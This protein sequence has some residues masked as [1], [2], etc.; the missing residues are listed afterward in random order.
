MVN[1]IAKISKSQS[2]F[3]FGARGT[4]KSTLLKSISFL[5]NA[6]VVDLLKPALEERY[7]IDPEF[8]R[9][10]CLSLNAGDWVIIDE[11][12][13]VPK[14]LN[15]V[16]SIIEELKINFALTGSSSRKLKRGSANML[17]GRAVT[18]SLFPFTAAELSIDFNLNDILT[19][20]SL[21]SI[22]HLTK[23][24]D[25][26]R[27]L[28]GYVFN[29]LKE[30][31]VAEQLVRNLDP[32]RLFLPIAAQMECQIINY[33]NIAKDS[34]VEHKTIQNYFQILVDTNIGFFLDSY[35][36]SVRKVQKQ[37]PK[38][39]FFDGGVKRALERKI[40]LKLE[41]STTDYGNAFEAWFIN[42]CYRMNSYLE[43][44]LKFS[45]LRTKDDV[46]IDLIV[47]KPDG[48]TLLVEIKSSDKIDKRHVK[49]LNH[50]KKD[51]AGAEFICASRVKTIQIIEDVKVM[52]YELA[53]KKII[54]R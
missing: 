12:Q 40:T 35:N 2:F 52:P 34:G 18:Y 27:Y 21:P 26:A 9:Q 28:R 16:H 30:E 45:Y 5:K 17:G 11:V 54:E 7:S 13:K 39:Y 8:L 44:D 33:S 37:A 41:P 43:L 19:W 49:N 51:F 15:I 48:Q 47:E 20:G 31:V 25:K 22:F 36:R 3:L 10:Q 4:G 50:F 6:L 32:F 14:L 24:E 29:Y 46:E 1:R 38:F 53:L 42:E 23:S